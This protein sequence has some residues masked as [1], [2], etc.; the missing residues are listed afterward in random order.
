MTSETAVYF[1]T[2]ENVRVSYKLA[3]PGT[4]FVA[5]FL[6][7][8]IVLIGGILLLLVVMTV[9]ALMSYRPAWT[10]DAS[11]EPDFVVMLVTALAI[12]VYGFSNVLYFGIYEFVSNGQTLG[13]RATNIRVVMEKGFTLGFTPV[14]IR[15]VFRLIDSVPLLWIVPMV[16][17]NFRRL[18]D[19][20]AGT[21]VISEE[22]SET[23]WVRQS[24][25]ETDPAT[26]FFTF[27]PAQLER[28]RPED[29]RAIELLFARRR[30]RLS[31][32]QSVYYARRLVHALEQRLGLTNPVAQERYGQFLANLL[33]AQ[34]RRQAQTVH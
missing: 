26:A 34:I 21:I 22:V 10:M 13:K 28:V 32:E 20:V 27:S 1:E 16:S 8:L 17:Q 4:R 12:V 25:A 23:A 19:M 3:G 31:E 2:P 24:L 15:S 9:A 18:G 5:F 7:E 29:E 6:D 30:T 14:A 11:L 33:T